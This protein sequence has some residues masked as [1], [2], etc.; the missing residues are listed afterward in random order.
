MNYEMW[1]I[2]RERKQTHSMTFCSLGIK[3]MWHK[4]PFLLCTGHWAGWTTNIYLAI[5]HIMR[6]V[7]YPPKNLQQNVASRDHQVSTT[8]IRWCYT[9]AG[10]FGGMSEK[11]SFFLTIEIKC[12]DFIKCYR[13]FNCSCVIWS[14]SLKLCF[15]ATN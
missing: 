1:T 14:E 8:E 6:V 4:H 12:V 15:L 5:V 2:Q 3:M 11:T 10:C 13:D 7:K 9:P